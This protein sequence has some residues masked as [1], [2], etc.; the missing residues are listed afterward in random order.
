MDGVPDRDV[1][2]DVDGDTNGVI[3]QDPIYMIQ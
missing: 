1:D 3:S 2:G